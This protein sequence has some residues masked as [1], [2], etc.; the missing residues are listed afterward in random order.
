MTGRI[1]SATEETPIEHRERWEAHTIDNAILK[2]SPAGENCPDAVPDS[3]GLRQSQS[4]KSRGCGS[5][6][7]TWGVNGSE[8]RSSG[9]ARAGT[10]LPVQ[11]PG[12]HASTAGGQ[13]SSLARE[14][15]SHM[16]RG[17]APKLKKSRADRHHSRGTDRRGTGG[18]ENS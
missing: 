10:P 14:L 6:N 17:V 4:R 2:K 5:G 3:Q 9:N 13:L 15:R 16:P 7:M 11:Q 12:L 18:D 8:I 1:V